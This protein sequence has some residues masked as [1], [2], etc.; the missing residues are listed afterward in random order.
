MRTLE[1]VALWSAIGAYALGFATLT[2]AGIFRRE[3]L[4][5]A[6]TA[7][8]VA[9]VAAHAAALAA[10]WIWTG[11]APVM[12]SYENSLAGAFFLPVVFAAAAW[13]FPAARRATPLVLAAT[14]LLVGNGLMGGTESRALE[15]PFRSSWLAVHV[16]FAWLAFGAYLVASVLA[17]HYLWVT[18]PS[19]PRPEPDR[20]P[21]LDELAAKLIA[22]GF[23]A[24]SV[25]I[26]SGAI[27]AHGLWGRYW[28]WDPIETWSLVSWLVYGVNLHLRFTLGWSGRRAA[29]VAV[30]SV[31]TVV[32]T[33]FGL[34]VVSQVHTMLL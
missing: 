3:R 29:W 19:A 1:A 18:R 23:V 12:G 20:R 26:A 10:R 30:G 21:A 15:P 7:L 6:G 34:G 28:A 5:R 9:G 25:M 27:W 22:F 17:G 24:D 16:T 2:A 11:H 32:L 8:A 14:L 31:T 4:R 13:R 33:F